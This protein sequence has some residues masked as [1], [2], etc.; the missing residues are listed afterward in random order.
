MPGGHLSRMHQVLL[1]PDLDLDGFPQRPAQPPEC[2]QRAALAAKELHLLEPMDP[3]KSVLTKVGPVH[4]IKQGL[5]P[6]MEARKLL[7]SDAV[8]LPAYVRHSYEQFQERLGEAQNE[9]LANGETKRW[10]EMQRADDLTR[11]LSRDDISMLSR[12]EVCKLGKAVQAMQVAGHK[13]RMQWD[14][15]LKD[16]EAN[17]PNSVAS[18]ISAAQKYARRLAGYGFRC[19]ASAFLFT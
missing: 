8:C 16:E 15:Q 1:A 10:L 17:V 4:P 6:A 12:A 9:A 19:R 7:K 2:L 13:A 11:F 14:A 5:V 18:S 3:E